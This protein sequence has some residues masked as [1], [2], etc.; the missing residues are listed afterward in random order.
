[1]V[2]W[3]NNKNVRRFSKKGNFSEKINFKSDRLQPFKWSFG[4][5]QKNWASSVQLF[6]QVYF[7]SLVRNLN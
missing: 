5:P 7:N 3:K 6:D 4:L 2:I 1:M